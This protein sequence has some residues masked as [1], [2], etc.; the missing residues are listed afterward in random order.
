MD[1]IIYHDPDCGTSRNTL[2]MTRSAGIAARQVGQG[3]WRVRLGR[4]V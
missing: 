3:K 1:A 2:A 4:D